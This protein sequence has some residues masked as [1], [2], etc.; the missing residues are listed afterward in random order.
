MRAGVR[1]GVDVGSVRVGVAL[2][3]PDGL[4]AT[5]HATL[6]FD[7]GGFTDVQAVVDLARER[8]AVEIVVGL[9][10]SLDG[11]EN[12]AAQK[13]RSW[14]AQAHRRADGLPVRLVDERMTTVD[15]HRAMR[16]A[17]RSTR[18]SRDV[19]DR[20][21]AVMILQTALD[22]ERSTGMPPGI[23]VGGRKPRH[24]RRRPDTDVKGGTR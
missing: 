15:A 2:C 12:A 6:P 21:A 5:P 7:G 16:E 14:A 10:L 17:G 19:I 20:Q 3:D 22:T 13:A 11:T 9:P 1:I 8:G 4:I 23:A 24:R 18:Q